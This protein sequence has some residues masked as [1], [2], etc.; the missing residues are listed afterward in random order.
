M[1]VEHEYDIPVAENDRLVLGIH[2]VIVGIAAAQDR[3]PA[4]ELQHRAVE[5][6][7]IAVS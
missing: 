1:P 7:Q 3:V 4:D 2:L 5:L 6:A